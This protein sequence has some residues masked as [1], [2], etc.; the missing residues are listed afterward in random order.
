[1]EKRTRQILPHAH[2]ESELSMPMMHMIGFHHFMVHEII[3]L[4]HS[5]RMELHDIDHTNR[6]FGSPRSER[7]LRAME[8]SMPWGKL[9]SDLLEEW[10]AD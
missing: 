5:Q 3:G 7:Q 2:D 8:M 1:M 6:S 4:P 9:D 10:R